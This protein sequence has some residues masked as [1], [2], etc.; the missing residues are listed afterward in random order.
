MKDVEVKKNVLKDLISFMKEQEKD[1]LKGRKASKED[2]TKKEESKEDLSKEE[3]DEE[4]ES[5]DE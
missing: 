5:V 3:D 4:E 2:V 1:Q